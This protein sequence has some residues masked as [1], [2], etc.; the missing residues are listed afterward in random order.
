MA[1]DDILN[2][3]KWLWDYTTTMTDTVLLNSQT[4]MNVAQ[5]LSQFSITA[6]WIRSRRIFKNRTQIIRIPLQH[7]F[8]PLGR[9]IPSWAESIC[10]RLAVYLSPSNEF[11][12]AK[13]LPSVSQVLIL[14]SPA[15]PSR[16]YFHDR[17]RKAKAGDLER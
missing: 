14:Q 8:S 11:F 12:L 17:D 2:T 6:K 7:T 4:E 3:R 15:Q 5:Y 1:I 9:G 16:F 10:R 13:I